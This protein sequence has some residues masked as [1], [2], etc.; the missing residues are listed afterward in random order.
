MKIYLS[1]IILC[2]YSESILSQTRNCGTMEHLEVL[3]SHDP[4]LE[5]TMQKNE[6]SLQQKIHNQSK[7]FFS[8][9]LTIPVV[10]HIIYQN[11]SQN[12]SNAQIL[13]QIDILNEDFR[14]NN[15][16]ASSVPS[17]FVGIAADSEIEFCLAV[18]DPIGNVTNGITRTSTTNSSFSGY[19][20][21]KYS[22][23]GGQDAWN[24]SNYLNIWV[25]N[26]AS[27]LLGFATFPGSNSNIDGVVC[28]YAYFGN[29]GTATYP[30]HLGRTA[31][32]EVGHW[33]NLYHIWGDS[34]CG[35]D[36]VSDT[37]KHEESNYG[38]PSFP[39]ASSCSGT[40]SNGEMFM[41]Y[42]DYTNDACMYMFSTGQKNRMR[43]TLTGTRS[44]LL[45]SNGCTAV[46]TPFA[47]S[48]IVTNVSCNSANIGVSNN[49][50][51]NLSVTGGTAPYTYSWSNG[52]TTQNVSNLSAGSYSV[53]VADAVGQVETAYYTVSAPSAITVTY[54]T[55][56]TS[57]PGVS[58]GAV[59]LN[60]SGGTAPLS[61]YWY[62]S[63]TGY[64]TSTQN[65][66]LVLAGTYS[67]YV[68]DSNGC[69]E[70][71]SILVPE[72]QLIPIVV[73]DNI[74][75]I[76]CYGFSDG[77]IDLTVSGGAIPYS[78]SWSNGGLTEDLSSLISGA[79]SVIITDAQ[80]Q[81]FSATYTVSEPN[82]LTGNYTVSDVTTAG[83]N[84]GEIDLFPTGGVSPYNFYWSTGN[85]TEDLS[86]L[87]AG[88]YDVWIVDANLCYANIIIDVNEFILGCTEPAAD[89]YDANAAV[90]DGSC[91]YSCL[92][93]EVS[94][95]LFDSY[96][97]GWS[98][99][100]ITVDGS[101]Y[102]L[103]TG[104]VDSFDL[105]IDMLGCID[106]IYTPGSFFANI[107]NSWNVTDALGTILTSGPDA[108]GQLGNGC[109]VY[110]CT[111]P[112]YCNYDPTANVDDGSCW[113][114]SGCTDPL[115]AEYS[116]LA[117]CDDGS[118][119]TLIVLCVEDA[120]TGLNTTDVIQNR[121]TINWDNMNSATCMV[122]QYRIKY[123]V[124][125]TSA[126]DQKTMG[127]PVNSCN[128]NGIGNQKIE[129][130]IL[131]L[132][133]SSDYEYQMKA[134]YCGGGSSDWSAMETFT[135]LDDCPNVGNLTVSS[136]S[137]TQA[138][139]TWDDSN[140]AYSFMR[141]KARVDVTGS[142]WFNVGGMG[143]AY[144]VYTKDKN[145]LSPG[146]SYRGQSRS[147]CDP[148]GGAY[149]SP[150]WTSLLYWTQP[151][152]V[153]LVN[154]E[155][156]EFKLLR[157]TDLLGR[158]VNPNTVIHN[159]ILIYIYNDGSVEKHIYTD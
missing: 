100:I 153:R 48:S 74:S 13:S 42:M 82:Q 99:A 137:T 62:N 45:S 10:V 90:D 40:G 146:T 134:W 12:I 108:S 102:T 141:I 130:L 116:Q 46:F 124:I 122:D 159:T 142:T 71:L 125:G 33:L 3:K 145:N 18:R 56:S 63:V 73:T 32:H 51:I 98:G 86:N 21:M 6:N 158:K 126:F 76:S 85:N 111:G 60:V 150:Q 107:E 119:A 39:H 65:L 151:T 127:G 94:L 138:T 4:I 9:V 109:A 113:G 140:G 69:Y 66:S 52:A 67:C 81:T 121:A 88:T 43:A 53:S 35:N 136:G 128:S 70:L 147:W 143:V 58:D 156:T 155:L 2:L 41:N 103:L 78:F 110:G 84:D 144:G 50:N 123:R 106:L 89:N 118:C 25:C 115:F 133:P 93:D 101:D 157:I 28:D 95:N 44:S 114:M 148:N 92:F 27:G 47:L 129:K 19:T 15:S 59:N 26:L 104:A 11:S 64:S 68:I 96:G 135:T 14:K 22:S 29:T 87:I 55:N 36:Y 77:V 16:D 139:F 34:Y 79:Y 61:Y 131:N 75:N 23:S 24:T 5:K 49:G 83:G 154:P 149:K 8:S 112:T 38:C 31:T 17:A 20:S 57:A 105:C 132:L 72:G 80:S 97:D 30:Y 37:P 7:S 152:T 1:I 120:P 91:I 117:T 54:T